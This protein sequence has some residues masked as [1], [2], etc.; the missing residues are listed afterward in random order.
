MNVMDAV[1]RDTEKVEL[2]KVL[3]RL[4]SKTSIIISQVRRFH[5]FLVQN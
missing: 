3:P 1:A 4:Q 2:R 5:H